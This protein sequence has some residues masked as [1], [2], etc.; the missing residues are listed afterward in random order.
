[1][2]A[3]KLKQLLIQEA[4]EIESYVINTRRYIHMRPETAFEEVKTRDLIEAELKKLDFDT[5]RTARTGVIGVLNGK[6]TGPTIALRADTDAL[7]LTEENDV[8]YASTIPGKMHACGHDAHT[9]MLL[10]AAKLILK[11]RNQLSGTLKLLFQ[12]AEEGGGG[13]K[14]ICDEGH[15]DDVD[16]IFGIHVWRELEAG[17]I[18]SRKGAMLASADAFIVSITGK[19]GHAAAPHQTIDPTAVLVDIYNALQKIVSR[20]IDPFSDVIITTPVMQASDAFNVIPREAK[21][22]GTFRTMDPKI[23]DHI[24]TRIPEIV[25]GYCKAWRC[26][27]SVTFNEGDMIP[28]PPLINDAQSVDEVIEILKGTELSYVS[29]DPSMGGEDFAFYLQKTKGAFLT[30]GIYNEEKGITS[31]HH[32]PHFDVDEA[33]LWK[34]TALYALL[35]FYSLFNV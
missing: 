21:L 3:K 8:E 15:L 17:I 14:L 11:Y 34:G 35:G 9:A 16:K 18:G 5:I 10:G 6:K 1:M 33:V 13:G 25:Q 29:M 32:H 20:E 27:G 30:L 4:K 7:N 26:E 2:N 28:Y 12:P 22:E 19:G 31:P 23:R 24:V